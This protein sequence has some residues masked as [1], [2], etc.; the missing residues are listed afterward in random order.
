MRGSGRVRGRARTGRSKERSFSPRRSSPRRTPGTTRRS[1]RPT[2]STGAGNLLVYRGTFRLPWLRA[3]S[4]YFGALALAHGPSRDPVEARD[5]FSEAVRLHPVAYAAAI[6]LGNLELELGRP[7]EAL[8]AWKT[9]LEHVPADDAAVREALED[10]VSRLKA[11]PSAPPPPIR[12]P[13]LE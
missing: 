1:A 5:R 13:W 12:N 9:A 10:R 8:A 6:E 3:R 4:L 11:R 7:V 2:R